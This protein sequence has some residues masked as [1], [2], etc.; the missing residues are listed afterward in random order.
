MHKKRD[1]AQAIGRLFRLLEA[2]MGPQHWWPAGGAFEV[3]VGAYLTQNTAWTNV[4]KAL[5][6]LRAAGVLSISGIRTTP[7]EELEQMVRPA[8]YFRQKAARLKSFVA[9]LD[10]HYEGSLEA[11]FARP[12][13]E[14]REELLALNGIGPET[15]DSILLYAAGHEVFVV[16]AYTRRVL[17]RHGLA[18]AN[19]GYEQIRSAAEQALS[20][21][22]GAAETELLAAAEEWRKIESAAQEITMHEVSMAS[23]MQRSPLAQRYNEF[24]ALLVQM[25]KHYCMKAAPRCEQCP[26]R[27]LLPSGRVAGE[28]DSARRR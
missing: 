2:A 16:D 15:A 7:L 24:H 6:N 22:D 12:L 26:L 13:A 21:L 1:K 9:H 11:M 25:G 20:R 4:E 5:S 28:C 10:E 23:A 19:D 17:E 8:G 27:S 18:T 14:L 3:V